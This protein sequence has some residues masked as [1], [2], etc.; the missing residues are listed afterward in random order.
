[1]Y[2]IFKAIIHKHVGTPVVQVRYG[3]VMLELCAGYALV[4]GLYFLATRLF[5]DVHCK[6]A[7]KQ[8]TVCITY[9]CKA[10]IHVHNHVRTAVFQVR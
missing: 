8:C 6:T 1:M 2:Y 9:V 5:Q 10:I 7:C 4:K 3:L